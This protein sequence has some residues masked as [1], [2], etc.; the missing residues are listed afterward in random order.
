MCL[1]APTSIQVGGAATYEWSP[2]YAINTLLGELVIV[3]PSNDFMYYCTFTNACG[4]AYDSVYVDVVFPVIIAG[5]DTTVCPN[6]SASLW[7]S[8]GVSYTWF[9]VQTI[10]NPNLQII[11]VFPTDTTIYYVIGMDQFGCTD[12]ASATVSLF[13]NAF[14]QTCPDVYAFFGDEVQLSATSTTPGEYIWSPADYLSC[15]QCISPIAN[16]DK[17]FVYTITYT[18]QNGCQASDIVNLSYD[19][20]IYIPNTFTPNGTINSVFQAKG[21]NIKTFEMYIF[22]RWG[23]LIYKMDSLEDSW[24]GKYNGNKC[25]DGTYT[26][27]IKYS[28][29]NG[30]KKE[31]NGH[32]NLLR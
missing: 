8:G 30:N 25:Q 17:N 5:N 24:D 23:E 31:R 19:G 28:D 11:T 14:I 18:D 29:F 21:G 10:L 20:I 15:T 13:P 22:D 16:P 32:V 12:T 3:N 26:W 27:T 1:G 7:A 6:N 4:N 2:N 9:P